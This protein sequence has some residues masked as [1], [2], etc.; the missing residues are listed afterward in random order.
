MLRL[1]VCLGGWLLLATSHIGDSYTKV[2]TDHPTL[3]SHCQLTLLACLSVMGGWVGGWQDYLPAV[4]LGM[5]AVLLDRFHTQEA[6]E[7]RRAS[8]P[9]FPDLGEPRGEGC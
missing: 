1:R 9:V 8:V 4:K 2:R 5:H 7:W 6:E 3:H